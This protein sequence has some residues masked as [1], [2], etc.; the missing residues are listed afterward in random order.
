MHQLSY[1]SFRRIAFITG[2]FLLGSAHAHHAWIEQ[3]AAG[4][5]FFFGEFGE[6]LRETSPGLLD[7]FV[8]PTGRHIT[9]AGAKPL[10]LTKSPRGFALPARAAQGESLVAEENTYPSFERKDGGKTTRGI[11]VPAARLVAGFAA[12]APVLTLDLVPTGQTGSDGVTLQ[13]FYEGKPLPKAKV[14]LVTAAGWGRE[15][16][17][18]EQGKF[19]VSLP[20]AGTYV[21]EVK[22]TGGPGERAGEKYER[23]SY[24]TSLTLMQPTGIAALPSPPPATPNK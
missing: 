24:V 7:K 14:S 4:A 18:D 1:Q 5:T 11:Y 19:Q 8:A 15:Y 21:L 22:H 6:N 10:A 12:Q 16:A 23:A 2:M 3:D 13:A 9:A 20:W 17:A